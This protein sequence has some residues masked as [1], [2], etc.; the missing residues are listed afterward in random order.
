VTAVSLERSGPVAFVLKGYPRLSETFIAQEIKGLEDLGLEIQL[1]S[2]RHPTDKETHPIHREIKAPVLY[3]PEYLRDEPRRL[4]KA[5]RKARALPGYDQAW[6]HWRKDLKRDRTRNRVRR[7][8]QAMVMATELNPDIKLFHAHFLHTPASVTRYAAIMRGHG[9]SFSAHAKDIW[10]S[11]DWEK[12]EKIANCQWGVTCTAYGA[13]HLKS[14]APKGQEDRVGL[15]YHGLDLDRF[16]SKPSLIEATKDPVILT[17]G[18]AVVKK[19][20]DTILDALAL[21][22]DDINWRF[23]HIGGGPLL[24][25]LKA[26]ADRLGISPRIDWRG[27][28]AQEE[29]LA[30]L[31]HADL[32]VLASRVGEDGDRDGLPNVLM[33]AQSQA[34]PVV[35]TTVSGIPE[36]VQNQ[37]TGLLVEPNDKQALAEAMSRILNDA[38]LSAELGRAGEDRVRG[39]FDFRHNL[40]ALATR[41]QSTE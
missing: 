33:E 16:A 12:R 17:V 4:A 31:R 34:V 13:T 38:N 9:W 28:V 6:A 2:L 15:V 26:Q 39:E 32:F 21:L 29:V 22:P 30:T 20:L 40:K 8:G 1:V 23:V 18:R 14:L 10:T 27:A 19:G 37:K 24:A 41:F 5:W 7:F 3:L 36:L 35:A 11:P 25:E